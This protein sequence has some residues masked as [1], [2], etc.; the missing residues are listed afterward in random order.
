MKFRMSGFT[1]IEILVALAIFSLI[2]LA[3]VT[4]LEEVSRITG[5]LKNTSAELEQLQ[6]TH[7]RI[8]RDIRQIIKRQIKD[9]LGGA[10]PAILGGQSATALEFTRQ[11]WRNPL[12]DY[13]SELQRVAYHLEDN[14]LYRL[15][16]QVLDRAPDSEPVRQL[17]L[18]GVHTF[19]VGFINGMGTEVSFWPQAINSAAEDITPEAEKLQQL[20]AIWI[21]LDTASFGEI[22]WLIPVDIPNKK[23]GDYTYD[24]PPEAG[25]QGTTFLF[26]LNQPGVPGT[27]PAVWSGKQLISAV[28]SGHEDGG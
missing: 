12:Y 11:N 5:Q 28:G 3:A 24:P 21:I 4:V 16:W 13:R 8:T 1:L 18:S 20:A 23:Y 7:H 14:N 9:E 2:G 15:Y 26:R 19:D 6:R 22:K 27:G 17:L 10:R 25:G